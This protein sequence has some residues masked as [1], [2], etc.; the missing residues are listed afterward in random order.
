VSASLSE[1]VDLIVNQKDLARIEFVHSPTLIEPGANEVLLGIDYFALTANN[2]TL[3]LAGNVL[4]YWN[5]FPTK[6]GWGRIPTWGLGTVIRSR[7]SEVSEGTRLFGY[8][9]MS[10][11]AKV[12]VGKV[13]ANGLVDKTPN[14]G[15]LAPMYNE[16]TALA[17]HSSY[18]VRYEPIWPLCQPLFLT[19]FLLDEQLK[20]NADYGA[21]EIIVSSASSKT[22]ICMAF[23]LRG[24]GA[25]RARIVGL[26]A[27]E[28]ADF[29]RG[30]GC[31]DAV[32]TY[33]EVRSL[34]ADSRVVFVDVAGSAEVTERVHRHFGPNVMYSSILGVS[35]WRSWEGLEADPS[36]PGAKPTLFFAPVVREERIKEWGAAGLEKRLGP[37]WSAFLEW[38]SAWLCI[39]HGTGVEAVERVYRDMLA[40]K[41]RPEHGHILSLA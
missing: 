23:L 4:G 38:S 12:R 6:D 21:Q 5:A 34:S 8:Y 41:C 2:I 33:S 9:P 32:L 27:A 1:M 30:V 22:A 10:T 36:L 29:V 13:T 17:E 20:D 18:D 37:A 11:H 7:H 26:T 28:N 31:Y 14:R 25:S 35:H 19:S 15:A 16:Y 24:R 39:A 40:G 3:A